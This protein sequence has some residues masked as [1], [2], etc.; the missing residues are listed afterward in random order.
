MTSD[1]SDLDLELARVF[2]ASSGAII[3]SMVAICH[4]LETAE[5]ALQEAIIKA[6]IHWQKDQLPD[7]PQGWLHTVAKRCLIDHLRQDDHRRREPILEG[8]YTSLA[9]HKISQEGQQE[10]PDHQLKLMFVCCH[11]ALNQSAQVA[12]T[13]KTLCG[14]TAREIARAF[15]LS[16]AAMR[17]RLTRAK[18]KIRDTNIAYRIPEGD[19]LKERLDSVLAVIYLIY[20]E[21]YTAFEGQNLSRQDL[22]NEAIRLARLL[23]NLLPNPAVLGLLALML[24]HQARQP[25]RSSQTSAYIPLEV[26]DRTLWNN[27]QISEGK[28][29]L[30]KALGEGKPDPYQLQAAISALHCEASS[31]EN[32]DW[33]QIHMLYL[34]LQ[35]L[36]PSPVVELNALVALSQACCPQDAYGQLEQLAESLSAYQPYFAAKADMEIKLGEHSQA[37]QSLARALE[38]SKNGAE[39]SYLQDKLAELSRIAITPK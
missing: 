39:Q 2:R 8:A 24:F 12:L 34:T 14:L 26:Q 18:D 22:A 38:L 32:T 29:L 27:E 17:R 6:K 28:T 9:N 20:N 10:I 35:Q 37:K 11:P 30:L 19:E 7:N 21:S 1:S 16:E 31:W 25:A 3:A 15:L 23:S 13:L 36:A 4:D 5:D 33:K